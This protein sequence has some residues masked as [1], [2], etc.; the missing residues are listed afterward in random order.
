[1]MAV[2]DVRVRFPDS[3]VDHVLQFPHIPGKVV[4]RQH[5][6]GRRRDAANI[7]FVFADARVQKV[8]GEQENVR[9]SLTKRREKYG[10]WADRVKKIY[11]KT[12]FIHGNVEIFG[13]GYQNAHIY[14]KFAVSV[15]MF[16]DAIAERSVQLDLCI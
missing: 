6:Y 11:V 1:M 8:L 2:Y 12:A 9:F 5:I 3:E 15:A 14:W 16:D 13:C 4:C 10:K 7:L